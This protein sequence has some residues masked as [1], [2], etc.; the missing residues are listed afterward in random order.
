VSVGEEV[1]SSLDH[2]SAGEWHQSLWHATAA[3]AQTAA[4]RYPTLNPEEA[5]KETIRADVD[6][7]G[8]MA[9]PDIDFEESR[10]PLPVGSDLS[11]QRPDIADVL[12]GVHRY[13]HGEES[14]M[15]AGCEVVP[16]VEGEP[17]FNIASGR[18]WLRASAALGLLA[19]SVFSPVNKGEQI[20]GS[21][22]LGWQQQIFHV[23]GWWGW[24]DH[25]REIVTN[26]HV[27]RV[28]LDFSPEWDSWR[29]VG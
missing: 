25:F 15:P 2:W 8:A 6:V 4:K 27:P 5:F 22:H 21:Y 18:L 14:A 9:G 13:L 12:Y 26:A 16:H 28:A 24:R 10:F 7:F 29:P 17:L 11:D 19:I 1:R 23:V 3:L 20:P